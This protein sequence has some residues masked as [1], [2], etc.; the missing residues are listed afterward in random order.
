MS[1][2][3]E[4]VFD[5]NKLRITEAILKQIKLDRAGDA[6]NK[7]TVK[8]SIQ[9]YVDLGLIKPKPMRTKEGMFLW[10][11]DRN[12]NIYDDQFESEF[13]KAT[14]KE[15]MQSAN[16]W[17]QIRNCPEYLR[18]VQK[19]LQNEESNADYWLQSETKTKMLKIVVLETITNMADAVSSKDTG[20]VHMFQQKN[21]DELKL[22]FDIFKRD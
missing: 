1:M 2:F 6:I 17:N 15:S 5:A 11:G 7:E 22:M 10:Q 19:M 4:R 13:L 3:H 9:V 16:L 21:L 18:E 20:C 12:L 14:Q 8:K